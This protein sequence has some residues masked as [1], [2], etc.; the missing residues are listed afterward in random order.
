MSRLPLVAALVLSV[1]GVVRPAQA[2]DAERAANDYAATV[3]AAGEVEWSLPAVPMAAEAGGQRRLLASLH[4]SLAAL[5]A[6][7]A[8]S[9]SRGLRAGAVEANPL[10]AGVATNGAAL[11]A[12]KAGVTA[13]TVYVAE[14]L[15]R[16]NRRIE[17]IAL[18]VVSNGMMAV[19]SARNA[20]VLRQQR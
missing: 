5:N 6:Y 17:A 18:M 7:D 3:A 4:V 16:K 15:W 20:S 10:M 2:N 11:W 12:V 19:V 1:F 8:Y 13:S 9:T 14:Q